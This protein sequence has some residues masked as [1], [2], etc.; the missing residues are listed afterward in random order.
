MRRYEDAFLGE[1]KRCV[2][3]IDDNDI[4]RRHAELSGNNSKI[5]TT[6]ALPLHVSTTL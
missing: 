4:D 2:I 5:S 1:S 6:L 3:M